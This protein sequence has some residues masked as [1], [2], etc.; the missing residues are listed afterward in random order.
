MGEEKDLKEGRTE[1]KEK[2]R[3]NGKRG[4]TETP[5]K[6]KSRQRK[7]VMGKK[8]NKKEEKLKNRS[9]T[10]RGEKAHRT[11]MSSASFPPLDSTEADIA[12]DGINESKR[13]HFLV[14]R[15]HP[16]IV[17]IPIDRR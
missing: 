1:A 10:I 3:D 17:P 4:Q 9:T 16:R 2:V 15:R 12:K 13:I 6:P 11:A 14:L 5:E 8:K 7:Q